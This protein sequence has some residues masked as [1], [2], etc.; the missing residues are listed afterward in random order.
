MTKDVIISL[1]I[2]YAIYDVK[3]TITTLRELDETKAL[4][5][6]AIIS[7][8]KAHPTDKLKDIL[9]NFY[10]LNNNYDDLFTNELQVLIAN[11]TIT[12]EQDQ[13]PSLNSF[14]GNFIIDEKVQK[15]LDDEKGGFFGNSEDKHT[16]S[17]N[18]KKGI[19]IDQTLQKYNQ[20]D[21]NIIPYTDE[22]ACQDFVN[23][24][25]TNNDKYD[26]V[27]NEYINNNLIA[28]SENLFSHEYKNLSDIENGT[29]L[30]YWKTDCKFKINLD[31]NVANI[32]A[33]GKVEGKIYDDYYSPKVFYQDLLQLLCSKVS[34]Q[35]TNIPEVT[36]L[37]DSFEFLEDESIINLKNCFDQN[38]QVL[39]V[40]ENKLYELFIFKQPVS[41]GTS[42]A[43]W[44]K[45]YVK[46]ISNDVIKS[47][48]NKNL[49][50][51][52]DLVIWIYQ[53]LNVK[54]IT[55][56]ILQTICTNSQTVSAYQTIINNNFKECL[57]FLI[58]NQIAIELISELFPAQIN[59]YLNTYLTTNK[60]SFLQL[61]KK[62]TIANPELQRIIISKLDG[63]YPD[64]ETYLVNSNIEANIINEIKQGKQWLDAA[65]ELNDNKLLNLYHQL[66]NQIDEIKK[67]NKNLNL[68]CLN[69]ISNELAAKKEEVKMRLADV[70][71]ES[72][73]K[74]A[75][76]NRQ[77]LEVD[78]PKLLSFVYD[79][80][81]G[82]KQIEDNEIVNKVLGKAELKQFKELQHFNSVFVH[83]NKDKDAYSDQGKFNQAL[84]QL[85]AY[86]Q[87]LIDLKNRI[88]A[89]NKNNKDNKQ[90]EDK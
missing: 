9:H 89:W 3:Y 63:N 44:T 36:Q 86:N 80:A 54:V 30:I 51:N 42:S 24:N 50:T 79:P 72:L 18:L 65:N 26:N 88:T 14:I 56:Y 77:I 2:P 67:L 71:F 25:L 83:G 46:E 1:P 32:F 90:K 10:H 55:A 17:I 16:H 64:N 37:N 41:D 87:F 43:T 85:K 19:F 21:R 35:L 11:K 49:M 70:N 66:N 82:A 29:N 48:I 34:C 8:K 74:Y 81:A 6:L 31:G 12:N 78:L 84:T 62:E 58:S 57:P 53:K 4:I 59:N 27:I 76:S 45:L 75:Q 7:N 38:D 47:L 61:L 20:N 33:Q 5:I 28:S 60:E 40:I 23:K 15:L 13:L 39:S 73:T 52:V 69:V 22:L 68:T